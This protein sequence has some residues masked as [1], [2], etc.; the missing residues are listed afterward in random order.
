VLIA[1]P[2]APLAITPL[3]ALLVKLEHIWMSIALANPVITTV[4]NVYRCLTALPALLLSTSA[5]THASTVRTSGA[6]PV[7]LQPSTACPVPQATTLMYSVLPPP[8]CALSASRPCP[9]V[10]YAHQPLSVYSAAM[11]M[12]CLQVPAAAARVLLCKDANTAS[13]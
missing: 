10:I 13:T 6:P 7:T 12:R 11:V 4:H 3:F 2:S 9:T 1:Q 8:S 5:T